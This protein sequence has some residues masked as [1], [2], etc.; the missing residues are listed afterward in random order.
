MS[1]LIIIHFRYQNAVALE[2]NKIHIGGAIDICFV[3][4]E[5]LK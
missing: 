3:F 1:H 4:Q 5:S 2:Q